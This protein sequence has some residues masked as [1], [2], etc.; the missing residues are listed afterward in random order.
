MPCRPST[1]ELP[2]CHR[3][4]STEARLQPLTTLIKQ[5][6]I[7]HHSVPR[8]P[9]LLGQST[10]LYLLHTHKLAG[11]LTRYSSLLT[12]SKSLNG[13]HSSFREAH[14]GELK[15]DES[16]E[17]V[18][19]GQACLDSRLRFLRWS[20]TLEEMR[21]GIWA[22]KPQGSH[23]R[24]RRQLGTHTSVDKKQEGRKRRKGIMV[25]SQASYDSK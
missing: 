2:S 25:D 22:G 24:V 13:K 6:P 5:H 23:H 18:E 20:C 17:G 14:H 12:D 4:R 1:P 19:R 11:V 16:G 3:Q 15:L 7:R 21:A 10:L 9:L 8:N